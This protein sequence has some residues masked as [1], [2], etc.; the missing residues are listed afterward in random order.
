MPVVKAF[1]LIFAKLFAISAAFAGSFFNSSPSFF[2]APIIALSVICPSF[3]KPDT[4]LLN[5]APATEARPAFRLLT[6]LTTPDIVTL[7]IFS[8]LSTSP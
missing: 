7:P 6:P 3:F 1:R 2:A 5:I 8:S 4:A